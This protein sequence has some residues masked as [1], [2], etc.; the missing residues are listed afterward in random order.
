MLASRLGTYLLG[1]GRKW[2]LPVA[3]ICEVLSPKPGHALPGIT[4][5]RSFSLGGSPSE[6]CSH[7]SAACGM[8]VL[9]GPVLCLCTQQ[10]YMSVRSGCVCAARSRQPEATVQCILHRSAHRQ[11]P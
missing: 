10:N 1:A 5:L 11:E 3:E 2:W 7:T 6:V 9:G 4:S 8:T